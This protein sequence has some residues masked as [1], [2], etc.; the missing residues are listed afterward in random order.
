VVPAGLLFGLLAALGWGVADFLVAHT[1]ARVG[2]RTVFAIAQPIGALLLLAVLLQRGVPL[3]PLVSTQVL[4]VGLVGAVALLALY[5]ALRM[6]PV[7][8]ASPIGATY[9]GIAALFAILVG[10]ESLGLLAIGG[11]VA[12]TVGVVLVSADPRAVQSALLERDSIRPTVGLAI[13]A[14]LGLGASNYLLDALAFSVGPI[15][16]VFGIRVVGSA[17]GTP[18]LGDVPSIPRVE[19]VP[20]VAV[21]VL[22]TGAFVAFALGISAER[23]AVVTPIASLFALVTVALA[24]VILNERLTPAQWVGVALVIFGTPLLSG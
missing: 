6:G 21:G 15:A 19:Y 5:T 4:V 8:I 10:G 1:G 12:I 9:G 22:D 17:V 14:A 7:A 23:V 3:A 2:E 11:A 18:F 20:L 16:A 13:L 24:R